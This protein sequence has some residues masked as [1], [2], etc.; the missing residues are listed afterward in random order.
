MRLSAAF[1]QFGKDLKNGKE[2]VAIVA[3]PTVHTFA[4]PWPCPGN[5]EAV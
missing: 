4:L 1:V 5:A 3:G 2:Y